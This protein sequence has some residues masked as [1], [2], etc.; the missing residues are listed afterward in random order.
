MRP[1]VQ[2]LSSFLWVAMDQLV[3]Q[4]AKMRYMF[5]GQVNLPIVYRC[6]MNYGNNTAAHHTDRPYP[7]F[8]NMP[9]LKIVIPTS[10]ADAKG[11]LKTAIRDNDPVMFFE[12]NNVMGLRGEVP[13]DEDFLIPFGQAAVKREG[14]DVT[15]VALAGMVRRALAVADALDHGRVIERVGH[16]YA[17]RH[18]RTQGAQGGVVGNIAGREQQRGFLAVKV[19]QFLLQQ[20]MIM[21]GAGNVPRAAGPG[22]A[23]VDG[24][25][26][27]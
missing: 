15:I 22:A 13:D 24:G 1:I 9:G 19:G 18:H 26:Q 7:M 14:S 25:F 5:G 27:A 17:A 21:I 4:A 3:S 6:G 20:D 8:M 16:D 10:P 11:L 2:S 23:L 12:D